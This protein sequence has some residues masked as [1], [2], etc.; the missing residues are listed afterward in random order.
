MDGI[1]FVVAT[2]TF[3]TALIAIIIL[4]PVANEVLPFISSSMG[5]STALMVSGMIVVE[6]IVSIM[7]WIRQANSDAPSGF[8]EQPSQG[9]F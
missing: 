2:M 6:I 5:N 1:N 4:I 3:V 7:V 8:Q 9:N